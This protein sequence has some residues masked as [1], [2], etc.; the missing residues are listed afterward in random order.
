MSEELLVRHCSPT[1]AGMKTGNIFSCSYS[2]LS[3]LREFIRNL[4]LRLVK[5][6]LRVVPIRATEGRAL[7]YVYRPKHLERDLKNDTAVQLL[8]Q[9]DYNIASADKC[10]NCLIC[11]LKEKCEFP[12][13]IGLFLG[14]PPEDVCGFIENRAED[15]K[16]VGTW[17]VYGDAESAQK[18]F[19][20][21]KKCTDVYCAKFAEGRPLDKLAVSD[22]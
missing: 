22:R 14:Y 4:N 10:V 19:A 16:C 6:G 2:E 11:R 15:F 17:K 1:L 21:Y 8:N 20:R 13:E 7:I 5:K 18:T 3:E 12:H 9:C